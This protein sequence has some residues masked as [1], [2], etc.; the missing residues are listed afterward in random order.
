MAKTAA[1]DA[2][3]EWATVAKET[4]I[5]SINLTIDVEAPVVTGLGD[6]GPRRVVGN[7]DWRFELEGPAD[8]AAGAS[9]AAFGKD[10]LDGTAQLIEYHPTGTD[11]A[12]AGDPNYDG[13]ASGAIVSSY[14]ITSR[15]GEGARW[16]ATVVGAN[17]LTRA[18]S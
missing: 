12:A 8:F 10:C 14:S 6:A 2:N 15:V 13:A 16:S 3:L 9:D 11:T 5:D 17:T 18:V 1:K 4:Y 7:Y